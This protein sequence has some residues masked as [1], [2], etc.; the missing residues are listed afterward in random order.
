[1]ALGQQAFADRGVGGLELDRLVADFRRSLLRQE[2]ALTTVRIYDWALLDFTRFLAA[3]DVLNGDQLRRDLIEDWQDHNRTHLGRSSRSIVSTAIRQFL[4]W[5]VGHDTIDPRAPYWV[6]HVKGQRHHPRPIPLEDLRPILGYLAHRR[7]AGSLVDL[8][9]RALFL[10]ILSTGAR[11]SEA[12][13]VRR[14]EM[15]RAIVRQKGGADKDMDVPPIVLE[16]LE[17]YLA[18]RRDTYPWMW[19]TLVSN[20]PMRPL[21]PAGRA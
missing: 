1:M 5:G 3:R 18:E 9:N 16:A 17:E 15:V 8:R 19:V 14:D 21:S 11:V 2:R 4:R 6:T 12:L 10:Y 13:Q 7:F 20:Y